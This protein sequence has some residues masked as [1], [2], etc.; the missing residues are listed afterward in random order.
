M[1]SFVQESSELLT[2]TGEW[3]QYEPPSKYERTNEW[4]VLLLKVHL[5]LMNGMYRLYWVFVRQLDFQTSI[6][7][8]SFVS[9]KLGVKIERSCKLVLLKE[10]KFGSQKARR[11]QYLRQLLI[12]RA[13][14]YRISFLRIY[15]KKLFD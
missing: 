2:G 13:S 8:Y 1:K 15:K 7:W 6:F 5:I 14:L 11:D 10:I 12:E 3:I 4:L 9:A